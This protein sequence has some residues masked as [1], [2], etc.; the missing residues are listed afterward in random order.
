MPEIKRTF[1]S[2]INNNNNKINN[3]KK[4]EKEFNYLIKN[5]PKKLLNDPEINKK[6][7]LIMKNIHELKQCVNNKTFIKKNIYKKKTQKKN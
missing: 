7:N 3:T 5:I 4:V 1:S 6:F 2:R